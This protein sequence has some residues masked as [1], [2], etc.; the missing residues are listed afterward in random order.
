MYTVVWYKINFKADPRIINNRELFTE[1]FNV[2]L[3][4]SKIIFPSCHSIKTTHF[5]MPTYSFAVLCSW[6]IYFFSF[7]LW[8]ELQGYI[9]V[10]YVGVLINCMFLCTIC[11]QAGAT[12]ERGH[13][14]KIILIYHILVQFISFHL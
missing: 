7:A 11:T 14:S 6:I 8:W 1:I 13:T 2:M 12:W 5:S 10:C 4:C 9:M 3:L